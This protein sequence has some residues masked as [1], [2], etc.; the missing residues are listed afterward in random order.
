MRGNDEKKTTKKVVVKKRKRKK[1]VGKQKIDGEQVY[2]KLK[3]SD[4]VRMP[5]EGDELEQRILLKKLGL[6]VHID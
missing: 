2:K 6:C 3:V 4:E 5:S 1:K